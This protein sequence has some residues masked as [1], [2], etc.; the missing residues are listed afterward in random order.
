MKEEIKVSVI[1]PFHNGEEFMKDTMNCILSQTL[2]EMEI[3]CVDDESTDSTYESLKQYADNDARV[4]VIR[5]EKSNAGVARNLGMQ[6]AEGKYLVF[7]DSDDLF[8]LDML[9]NMYMQCEEC[10]ADICICDADQYDTS[11][12]EYLIKPQYLR[13]KYLPENMPCSGREIGKYI[14]YFTSLVPWNKMIRK[15]YL[16]EHGI[17]FQDIERANDQYFSCMSLILAEKICIVDKILVHYRVGQKTSLTTNFAKTPLCSVQAMLEVKNRLKE[18]GLWEN[19]DIRRAFDNKVVNLIL[20]SLNIQNSIDGYKE[21]YHALKQWGLEKLE[22]FLH[23]ED[24]YFDPL[25]YKNLSYLLEYDYDMYLLIKCREY[26]ETIARKNTNYKNMVKQKNDTIK[27]WKDQ[28][29]AFEKELKDIKKKNWYQKI[30][31][32]IDWYH[33]HIKKTKV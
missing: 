6:Y 24:Y 29:K 19:A 27:E 18:D 21:L 7:L 13:K 3:I 14:L 1:I 30:T 2:K 25:E 8:E 11:T 4:K 20:F 31:R 16:M 33:A 10:K 23:E 5:Q 17:S 28:A 32:F 22:V 9:E 15:D 26:R 12:G